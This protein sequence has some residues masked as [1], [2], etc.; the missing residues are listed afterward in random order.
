MQVLVMVGGCMEAGKS[1]RSVRCSSPGDRWQW[2]RPDGN[3]TDIQKRGQSVH[4][5]QL[6][7]PQRTSSRSL[8][9]SQTPSY[10]YALCTVYS[11]SHFVLV[12]IKSTLICTFI[13][14]YVLS[15]YHIKHPAN[16]RWCLCILQEGDQQSSNSIMYHMKYLHSDQW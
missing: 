16:K 10:S 12:R 1:L 9:K 5:P 11:A 14:L 4:S 8:T 13:Y 15:T 7:T 6:L 2:L 3:M